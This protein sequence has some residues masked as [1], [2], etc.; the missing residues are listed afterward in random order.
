MRGSGIRAGFAL[1]VAAAL[2]VAMAP[3]QASGS[4]GVD[5]VGTWLLDVVFPTGS[6]PPFRE[7]VT[8]NRD[9]TMSESNGALHGSSANYFL[10][11]NGSDGYGNWQRHP[12]GRIAWTFHKMVFCGPAFDPPPG[13]PPE[14]GLSLGCTP[15]NVGQ[16]IGY[17]RVRTVGKVR[18][19]TFSSQAADSQVDLLIDLNPADG[20]DPAAPDVVIPFG[21]SDATGRRL[22]VQLPY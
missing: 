21:G 14:I 11:Y 8:F 1:G 9:G 18:G 6:P 16:H 17:L 5:P 10:N 2:S 12:G 19:D 15:Q 13:V 3:A 22:G 7:F 20:V 4:A